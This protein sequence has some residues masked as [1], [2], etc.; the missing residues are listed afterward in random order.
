MLRYLW[1]R[2]NRRSATEA[3]VEDAVGQFWRRWAEL[4][5]EVASA[6]DSDETA[7]VEARVAAAVSTMDRRLGWSMGSGDRSPYALMVT[8]EGDRRLRT[9][10][11]AWLAAAPADDG[12][13]YHDAAPAHDDPSEVTLAIGEHNLALAEVRVTAQL[14][15]DLVHVAV[16][17]PAMAQLSGA[18]RDALSFVPLDVALGERLVEQRIG[19][20]EPVDTEPPGATDLVGLRALVT[21]R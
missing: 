8:G 21:G 2:R 13:E 5:T 7:G 12:W 1:S 20:V 4:R 3:S 18:Q 15:G 16:F 14:S 9:L 17:H 19:R 10:T 11:D 6:L